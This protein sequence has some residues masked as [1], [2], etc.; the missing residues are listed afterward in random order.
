MS[1]QTS[2]NSAGLPSIVPTSHG[3]VAAVTI[4]ATTGIVSLTNVGA[5]SMSA[6]P[7]VATAGISA[8]TRITLVQSNIGTTQLSDDGTTP[9]SALQLQASTRTLAQYQTLV[10]VFDG[11]YW[12]EE[13]YSASGGGGPG[14]I[15]FNSA[16][17]NSA[18]N[19][20][21]H[22]NG[23]GLTVTNNS[24]NIHTLSTNA[25]VTIVPFVPVGGLM[26]LWQ[27]TV[28]RSTGGGSIGA[29]SS[30]DFAPGTGPW[31]FQAF[32]Y[33]PGPGWATAYPGF[34]F[35][36][37]VGSTPPGS[38]LLLEINGAGQL[39]VERQYFGNVTSTASLPIGTWFHLA[40]FYDGAVQYIYINGMLDT[41]TP[42]PAINLTN[43]N[44]WLFGPNDNPTVL[45]PL[46]QAAEVQYSV[47]VSQFV[48]GGP[49]IPVP[50]G[51]VTQGYTPAYLPAAPAAGQLALSSYGAYYCTNAVGPVWKRTNL[52]NT[53]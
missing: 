46:C 16:I 39:V 42:F 15:P 7:T 49:T 22:G 11:T 6:T 3:P 53:P 35:D 12:C 19:L 21:A 44:C 17:D 38:S 43:G 48:G 4:P 23:A 2:I 37:R 34:L 25:A 10:L 13:S 36:T 30:S 18:I 52:S 40:V 51:P 31:S 45:N 29:S 47:G 50:I 41:A 14:V 5:V 1:L 27:P 33:F 8:G 28:I 9:G 20:C 26:P 24:F 32:L